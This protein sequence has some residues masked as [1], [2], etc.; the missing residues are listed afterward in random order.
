MSKR[1]VLPSIYLFL[2]F[3]RVDR[4]GRDRPLKYSQNPMYLG[5]VGVPMGLAV[6]FADPLDLYSLDS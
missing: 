3:R 4:T 6:V 2:A 5:I 1:R